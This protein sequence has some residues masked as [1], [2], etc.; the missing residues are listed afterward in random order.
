MCQRIKELLVEELYNNIKCG[1][2]SVKRGMQG[3]GSNKSPE[4]I[5]NRAK[6][7]GDE[8]IKSLSTDTRKVIKHSP[9]DLQKR[10]VDREMKKRGLVNSEE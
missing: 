4:E 9:G 6:G 5:V 3:W 2:K 1:F 10:V 8:T 7:Y